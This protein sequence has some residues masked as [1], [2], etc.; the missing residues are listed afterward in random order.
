[1][2]PARRCAR[3][4]RSCLPPQLLEYDGI[5]AL[6]P[7]N[8]FLEVLVPGPVEERVGELALV[9]ELSESFSELYGQVGVDLEPVFGRR[10]AEDRLVHAVDPAQLVQR[11][12]MLVYAYV[13][14]LVGKPC[15]AAVA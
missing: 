5:D 7:L 8:A 13:D 15:V 9:A 10:L 6:D 11:P 3:P 2:S 12:G 4:V 1:M 14:D